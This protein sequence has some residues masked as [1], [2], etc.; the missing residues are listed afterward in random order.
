MAV[1]VASRE[2]V[3]GAM[4]AVQ[5][6]F[7]MLADADHRVAEAYGVYNLLEDGYA[8]PAVFVI[9]RDGRIAWSYVGRA[10]DDRPSTQQILDHL[11]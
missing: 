7:P 9:G 5:A 1:A 2:A 10:A 6:P 3:A 4:S 11:P 8:A